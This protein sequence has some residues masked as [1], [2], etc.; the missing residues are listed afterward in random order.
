[1]FVVTKEQLATTSKDVEDAKQD[2]EQLARFDVIFESLKRDI[3]SFLADLPPS[4]SAAPGATSS[5]ATS[6]ASAPLEPPALPLPRQLR[7]TLAGNK[8]PR[9]PNP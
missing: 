6:V 8:R 4:T 7:R 3:A 5:S 1:V 2:R 9:S